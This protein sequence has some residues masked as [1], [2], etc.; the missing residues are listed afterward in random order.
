MTAVVLAFSAALGACEGDDGASTDC[1]H[2]A[3]CS[4]VGELCFAGG[5]RCDCQIGSGATWACE[6]EACP[7][8]DAAEGTSCSR[9]A[10]V[11]DTGFEDPGSLCV[12]PE[13]TWARCRYYHQDPGFGPPNGCPPT[14]P[15][16]GTP[17]CQGLSPGGPELGCRYGA[18][19]IDCVGDHWVLDAP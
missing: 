1:A 4:E 15:T 19:V 12:G 10:L 17:C 11:C 18:Q 5:Q 14:A 16:L 2:H 6:P 7:V 13:L 3:P 8:G 9:Q